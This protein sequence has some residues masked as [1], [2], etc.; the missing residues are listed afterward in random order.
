MNVVGM[1]D[2]LIL[3]QPYVRLA[4]YCRVSSD[5]EDQLH[6]FGAQVRYYKDY[7]R[8]HPQ[9]RL[10]DIY[11]DEGITGTSMKK[12]DEMNRMLRDCKKGLIDRIVVKSVARFARNTQE[13]LTTIRFLKAVGVSVYFEEQGIDTDKLNSEMIV[14]FPGMVAQKESETI[15]E[16]LRWS[17]RKRMESGAF[18]CCAP[19]YGFQLED[20]QLVI[21]ESEAAVIRR[22]FNMYLEGYGLPTIARILNEEKIPCMRG[23]RWYMRGISYILK[24]ERYMGDAL[25]QKH[26][27]TETLPFRQV[28]NHGEMPQYYVE[29]ANPAIISKEIFEAAGKLIKSRQKEITPTTSDSFLTGKIRCSQCGY[30]YRRHVVRGKTYWVCK[31]KDSGLTSCS[32]THIEEKDL[33]R[34]LY[35]M[36]FKLKGNA[37]RLLSP[38]IRDMEIMQRKTG[39]NRDR[40]TRIDKEIADLAAR[41]LVV[42]R[43]YTSGALNS[44]DYSIKSGEINSRISMLRSERKALLTGEET[45]DRIEK[46]KDL[47]VLFEE[48]DLSEMKSDDIC[49]SFIENIL[50][51]GSRIV[52]RLQGGIEL[53]E[54]IE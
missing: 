22:I 34:I 51:D 21:D 43:L 30:T 25:L 7:E 16:N 36:I 23:T 39:R 48:N 2:E 19:A 41:N 4:A 49:R 27:T 50:I 47:L 8:Q 38:L 18:N 33:C 17:Y 45:D 54:W 40:I 9:Y 28:K 15:S 11:A 20:G 44:V 6:S 10:V 37:R 42:V 26:Y 5:S 53:P 29:N 52:F 1:T 13:L 3:D 32:N 35:R 14:T 46:L 24:N 31:G 12:R